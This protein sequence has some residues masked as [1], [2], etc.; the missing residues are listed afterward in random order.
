[1]RAVII[2]SG[3]FAE[4][5]PEGEKR[6]KLVEEIAKK[7]GIRVIGPNCIGILDNFSGVDTFFL[8]EDRLRRP[9]QGHI[10]IVSQ[11]GALLSMWIDWMA[12][13]GMGI[14][15]AI[16]YGNKMDLDDI[17]FIDYLAED[18]YT[19]IILLYIEGLK[20]SRGQAFIEVVRRAISKGKAV[21]ALKGGRTERGFQAAASHTA[22][23][24][25]GYEVYQ[26]V[27]KQA[28]II[29][30][31]T[32]EEM[33]DIA[34][35]LLM[36]PPAKGKR[37]L[38]LTNAGGEGVLATDYA[39][40]LGL[41]IP[42]LPQF[43]REELRSK[44]PPHVVVSNPID[45][46]G[47]TDDERYKIVLETILP[48]N[49]VD[50]V[51]VIAPPHPPAISGKIVDYVENAY[52]EF[53]IPIIAVVTGGYIAEEYIKKFEDRGIPAYQTP[54]RAAKV[55]AALARFGEILNKFSGK[56]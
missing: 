23:L 8:P 45:L 47:D 52:K 40:R 12:M 14:A 39:S 22:A 11:S 29:E 38:I 7:Y 17:D 20:P 10:S 6:Q 34:K 36:M 33:F 13:K 32:M 50:I 48:K 56:K 24:A 46:T 55:A 49:I 44:L 3:G 2:V 35:A 53:G 16:S 18:P 26:A 31:D 5:G 43:I 9:P 27:F 42:V 25:S 28:G 41:E 51:I 37:V 19:K 54:E 4:L 1:M 15:K 21:I 30:V